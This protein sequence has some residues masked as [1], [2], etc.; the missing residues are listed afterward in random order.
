MIIMVSMTSLSGQ[1][2]DELFQQGKNE[3]YQ[4]QYRN[5]RPYF[6]KSLQGYFA[7]RNKAKIMGCFYYLGMGYY[8]SDQI[9]EALDYTVQAMDYGEEQ[10][11]QD[12]PALAYLNILFGKLYHYNQK[13]DSAALFY[14]DAINLI[15]SSSNQDKLL[16]GDAYANLGYA[17]DFG[18]QYQK[19]LQSYIQSIQWMEPIFGKQH[20][21]IDWLYASIPFPADKSGN[22]ALELEYTLLSWEIKKAI[23]GDN[24]QDE[25]DA[26]RAIAVAYEHLDNYQQ[27]VSY[28][29]KAFDL[30]QK[31]YDANSSQI[32]D[33]YATFSNMLS[34]NFEI[35]RALNYAN[36]AYEIRKK[37]YGKNAPETYDI[38]QNI[39]NIYY[40]A[41]NYTA[42][43][44]QYRSAEKVANSINDPIAT[45]RLYHS[46]ANT[47]ESL[48]NDEQ[49]KI[50]L[51]KCLNIQQQHQHVKQIETLIAIARFYSSRSDYQTSLAYLNDAEKIR[52]E[53]AEADQE[54]KA[55]IL[56]NKGTIYRNISQYQMAKKSLEEALAIRS[57]TSG[58]NS[59]EYEQSLTNFGL[60]LSDLGL[61]EAAR[62][63]LSRALKI[64]QNIKS[65]NHPEIADNLINLS[66]VVGNL[67][68]VSQEIV[69]LKQA[70]EILKLHFE[71]D[72]PTFISI[73]HN[74][75]LALSG[76]GQYHE[77][78]QYIEMAKP[79]IA[80]SY[81][82]QSQAMANNLIN[83][84]KILSDQGRKYGS[85]ELQ[86]ESINIFRQIFKESPTVPLALAYNNIGSSYMELEELELA[87]HYLDQSL[88]LYTS[89]FDE[90]HPSTFITR[91][92]QA[93]LLYK[94]GRYDEAIS[95]I[96]QN[97][98][99]LET[100]NP[101]NF[102]ELLPNIR[103]KASCF[104]A[105]GNSKKALANNHQ[106]L[107]LIESIKNESLEIKINKAD[108]LNNTGAVALSLDSLSLAL[109]SWQEALSMYQQIYQAPSYQLSLIHNNLSEGYSASGDYQAALKHLEL[110]EQMNLQNGKVEGDAIMYFLTQVKKVDIFFK[111]YEQ[112]KD[113]NYLQ[114]AKPVLVLAREL[115]AATEQSILSDA[116]KIQYS[117]WKS[118]LTFIG[119]KN[120]YY[121]YASNPTIELFNE[122]FG[123]AEAS[124]ANILLQSLEKTKI[125][126]QKG[127]ETQWLLQQNELEKSIVETR[128]L[129]FKN[130][131]KN[132]GNESYLNGLKSK[133]ILLNEEYRVINQKIE[134][135]S[136]E[137][138]NS[139]Q[140]LSAETIQK[141]M[142][143]DELLVE[144]AMSDD[145]LFIII[146]AKDHTQLSV[147]PYTDSF[148]KL[149][150]AY[151]NAIFY[152]QESAL[153]I[154]SERIT[155]LIWQPVATAINDW[156]IEVRTITII[157]EGPLNYLPFEALMDEKQFLI[158]KY[159]FNYSYSAGLKQL[160][161]QPQRQLSDNL[162]SFAP[163][164]EDESIAKMTMGAKDV[165]A[166]SRHFGDETTRGFTVRG[167][168]ISPLPAT[169]SEVTTIHHIA[170]SAGAISDYY[171]QDEASE[172]QLKQK[173]QNGYKYLHFATHGF[174]N[175][176][177]PE[178]SGVFLSQKDVEDE[179]C[180]LFASEIYGLDIPAE[181][182]TLSACETGLGKF[183]Q[184]E[185]IV[186]LTRAF[187]YA[188]TRN[189][190]VSQWQVD[191]N[192]TSQLMIDFYQQIFDESSKSDALRQAKINLIQSENYN[193]PYFWAPFVLIGE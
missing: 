35:E 111:M 175:E 21:Y 70:H 96:D 187:L 9:D 119:I 58:P 106:A 73:Y 134:S 1:S 176:A 171:L 36:Q 108:L 92:N 83:Q 56:N 169:K 193:A 2:A 3:Y 62:D 17:Q 38:I 72:H 183:A 172:S 64:T 31:L 157:P 107:Q 66:T 161:N 40:D 69:L 20:A 102:T 100:S 121:Q 148:S 22:H 99:Y 39:G 14:E 71:P 34:G 179:D 91:Y 77:A 97:I 153:P 124:K 159:A 19:A 104:H 95:K 123:Y 30:Y 120:A 114:E 89:I 165:F 86:L 18:V 47:F 163:V 142:E 173:I 7:T 57:I 125:K 84:Q 141:S 152:R 26:L 54:Q 143:S 116:D 25:A 105:Q 98:G 90:S 140:E 11:D 192:S 147:V 5:S 137:R 190:L 78:M 160:T 149:V 188:G 60:L 154:V 191:D 118:L 115:L 174:V 94:K 117:V 128:D 75:G 80:K 67:G 15:N 59:G 186:G 12:D 48:G 24:T 51:D 185:G 27:A 88:D 181:L 155:N 110:A 28:F 85:I 42:A 138:L 184:G 43:L 76:M 126:E 61:L 166:A 23:W 127:V 136:R 4:F 129:L 44:E 151:R 65:K 168:Y 132:A 133:L 93:Q 146:I 32:A 74:M 46:I 131:Y 150:T 158:E 50:Y 177:L 109:T 170:K 68:N 167:D 81:G 45:T 103:L 122:A 113:D 164:F 53:L 145:R 10:F 16:L 82:L 33:Q 144:Y 6:E 63:T 37:T 162:L 130:Q 49:S 52:S 189:L 41:G 139:Y 156:A 29:T 135:A 101:D 13:Y 8:E 87:G 55:F 182:V 180:I 112:T 178:Y 79:I